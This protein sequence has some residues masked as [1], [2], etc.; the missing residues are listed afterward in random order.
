MIRDSGAED[1][2]RVRQ[3]KEQYGRTWPVEWLKERDLLEE[4]EAWSQ[5]DQQ[6]RRE[7]QGKEGETKHEKAV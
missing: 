1:L 5:V 6:L 4:A 7:T 2:S 3:L